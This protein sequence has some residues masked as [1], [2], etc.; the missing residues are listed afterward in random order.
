M[1]TEQEKLRRLGLSDQLTGGATDGDGNSVN[2]IRFYEEQDT[3]PRDGRS[4]PAGGVEVYGTEVHFT[5]GEPVDDTPSTFD[6]R[7]LVVGSLQQVGVPVDISC[8]VENTGNDDAESRAQLIENGEVVDNQTV[9]LGPGETTEITF[10]R[11]YDEPQEVTVR[12]STTN[13]T[14][15]EVV[16]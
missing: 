4:I 13:E 8:T 2:G 1:P 11:T 3:S 14:T 7:D 5:Q 10:T 6:Y 9:S 12:I 15:F 16:A